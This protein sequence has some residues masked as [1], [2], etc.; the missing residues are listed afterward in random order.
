[1]KK[2]ILIIAMFML[3]VFGFVGCGKSKINL[4]DYLIE[5]RENLF[6]ASDDLY[7]VSFSTG[8]READYNFDGILNEMVPF[9]VLTL[10]RNENLPLA[11]DTYTYIVTI[12]EQTYTG[13]L[14]KGNNNSYSADLEVNTIGDEAINVQISFTGYT[15][16]QDLSNTSSSFQV[17]SNTA[18]NI[19]QEELNEDIENLLNDKNVKIE[20]VMKLMKDYSSEELKNYYW[21][22]GII[23]TNGDTLGILIDANTGDVIAKKV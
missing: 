9:G 20:V 18:L 16:N 2:K 21:Y 15:F 5:Q 4:S 14:E 3:C 19:A 1:M 13:F 11:N 17:D 6:T 10:T 8:T 7:S 22:V 23:S 12:N